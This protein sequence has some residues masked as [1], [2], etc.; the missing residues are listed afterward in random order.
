MS[1]SCN[2]HIPRFFFLKR[3]LGRGID[4]VGREN[5]EN[6]QQNL[7]LFG[8]GGYFPSPKALKKSLRIDIQLD[9]SSLNQVAPEGTVERCP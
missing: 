2:A 6:I 8:G 9:Y 7:L 4:F 5:V 1:V 3:S